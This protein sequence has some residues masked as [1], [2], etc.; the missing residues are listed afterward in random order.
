MD[1]KN[2][3]GY[4]GSVSW[5][6]S[7]LGLE[8]MEALMEAMGNPQQQLRFVHV[9]GTNGKGSTCS[10][11]SSA[12][13]QA[14]YCTGLYT[15]PFVGCFNE[16]MQV[17]GKNITDDELTA[18]TDEVRLFADAME[19]HPT[20]FEIV[21]ALAFL[22]F[23]RKKCDIVVLEVGLGG[24]LDATNIIQPPL[25]SV[26][27]SIGLD[28][29]AELGNSLVQIAKEKAGVIK[30]GSEVVLAAGLAPEAEAELEEEA[31]RCG[32]VVHK[33]SMARFTSEHARLGGQTFRWD[34]AIQLSMPLAGEYQKINA[35]TA[36]TALEVL[37]KMGFSVGQQAL[38]DGFAA[39]RWP[40]RL[41][42]LHK[43]PVFMLDGGHNL[44]G[45]QVLAQSLKSFFP[46]RK[47]VF[48]M[49][50]MQD[51]NW[52]E[53]AEVMLPLAQR[54]Y[55][56]APDMARAL[57]AE[58]LAKGLVDLQG[59]NHLPACPCANVR[60]GVQAA[61]EAAGTGGLVCAFGSLYMAGTIREYFGFGVHCHEDFF[62]G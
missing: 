3:I 42:L 15:S 58:E 44:Q 41:E 47:W 2:A 55:C 16:R 1:R 9:A 38:R 33:A 36:L 35:A 39:A 17:N 50:V 6:V 57:P 52:K 31:Q 60:A 37:G 32:A 30:P 5:R 21:T 23:L 14:G 54:F 19:D 29:V 13:T 24:R 56:V 18:L 51:K 27:T 22:F 11:L 20:E 49:G 34:G 7:K 26:I 12:L 53:M 48:V 28:H 43:E 10:L 46:S 40:A 62:S 25:L 8:R 59:G 45:V 4:I 61:L